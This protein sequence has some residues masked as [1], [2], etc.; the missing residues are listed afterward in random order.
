MDGGLSIIIP[1][2]NASGWIGQT[3]HHLTIALANSG[4]SS[5]EIIVVDDGSSDETV[6]EVK[7]HQTLP[8]VLIQQPNRGRLEARRA[9]LQIAQHEFVLFLDTRVFLDSSALSFVRPLLND[10]ASAIWTSHVVPELRNNVYAHF[11]YG[12]E[13]IFWSRY[14]ANPRTISF[15]YEEFDRFPKGTTALIAPAAILRDAFDKFQPRI[16]D[17]KK[18]NDDTTILRSISETHAINISP[19][20]S[21]TY[22]ARSSMKSFMSHARHRGVV[23]IDGFVSSPTRLRTPILTTLGIAPIASVLLLFQPQFLVYPVVILPLL[24]S[25]VAL[26]RGVSRTTA[27]VLALL[28]WPFSVSYLTGMYEGIYLRFFSSR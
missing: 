3:L 20:Y 1:A 12:I 14:M 19:S 2:F 18:V 16:S 7:N 24:T 15:G 13:G 21:S 5:F 26:S 11:W 23:L 4:F 6:A 8:I 10:P 28:F 9:G 27:G 25:I 17:P 22:H